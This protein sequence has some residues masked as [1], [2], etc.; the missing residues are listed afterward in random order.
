MIGYTV[1]VHHPFPFVPPKRYTRR[2]ENGRVLECHGVQDTVFPTPI[3]AN[4]CTKPH[5]FTSINRP[6]GDGFEH[7]DRDIVEFGTAH[8]GGG[9]ADFACGFVCRFTRGRFIH[10][11]IVEVFDRE[12]PMVRTGRVGVM[13]HGDIVLYRQFDKCAIEVYRGEGFGF[14][15]GFLVNGVFGG[16]GI[17]RR[18]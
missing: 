17:G 15:E 13:Y 3:L 18:R 4:V 2:S 16:V 10:H 14:F 9:F 11:H 1:F 6:S 5:R 12:T 8:T 7:I